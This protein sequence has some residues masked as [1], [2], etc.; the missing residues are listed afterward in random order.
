MAPFSQFKDL[1]VDNVKALISGCFK[2]SCSVDL[3]LTSL[4]VECLDEPAPVIA[5]MTNLSLS[6]GRFSDRW[7]AALVT[8]LLKQT[9]AEQVKKNLRPVSNPSYVS[10][11]TEGAVVVQLQDHIAENGLLVVSNQH[12]CVSEFTATSNSCL[13]TM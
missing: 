3:M 13:A 10:K 11:L 2:K 9:G 7:K 5:W 12:V 4:V 1:S 8:P 6:S